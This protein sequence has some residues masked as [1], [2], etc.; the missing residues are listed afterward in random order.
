M[1]IS[2]PFDARHLSKPPSFLVSC[3]PA[4]ARRSRR[5]TGRGR[6]SRAR[7][8]MRAARACAASSSPWVTKT[9]RGGCL[10]ARQPA[11]QLG[12]VGVAREA[13]EVADLGQHGDV[14]LVD[15]HDVRAVEQRAA[16]R[17]DGL[18]AGDQQR[19]LGVGQAHAAVVQDAPAREH[20]ARGDDHGRPLH[21]VERLGL[22]ARPVQLHPLAVQRAA[23]PDVVQAR[24][25]AL[26]VRRVDARRVDRHRA[27]DVDRERPHPA[28]RHQLVHQPDHLLR[29]AHR[30]RRD[31]QHAAAREGALEDALELVEHRQRRV[32][33][34]AV[35]ALDDHVVGLRRRLRVARQDRRRSG[36]RRR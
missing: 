35:G 8:S 6:R 30:E 31:Q 7:G 20:A 26:R 25:A 21:R 22:R 33:A 36:P 18:V 19:V 13:L 14:S 15:P 29:P 9:P 34:V 32:R 1:S 10:H 28:L 23:A 4:R 24:L 5:A 11:Q 17:P 16:E 2:R 3:A 27:V 12:R